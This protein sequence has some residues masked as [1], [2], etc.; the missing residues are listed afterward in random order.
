MK[1]DFTYNDIIIPYE[2]IRKNVKN[3]NI[4]I[5]PTCEMVVSCNNDVDNKEIEFLMVKRAKWIINTI[6]EYKKKTIV[7]S[8]INYKLVDG[9]E[10]LLL[11]KVLRIKNLESEKFKVANDNNYLYIYRDNN[12]IDSKFN[13]WY[14]NYIEETYIRILNNVYKK[15]KKYGIIK[16]AIKVIKMKTR[17]GTCNIEKKII[18]LN[19]E[20]IKVDEFLIEFV[21]THEM[22][23]FLYK[24]HNKDFWNFLTMIMLDWKEREKILYSIFIK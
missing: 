11:G 21:I 7:F 1:Y 2:I 5:K 23:H 15:F 14:K 10:F 6:N 13:K 19:K 16:P 9:E 4:R 18:S 8:N 22:I 3:I 17:W 12:K 20:L 24:N